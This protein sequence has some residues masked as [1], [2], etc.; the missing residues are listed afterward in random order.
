MIKVINN[1][2]DNLKEIFTI[3]QNLFPS[4]INNIISPIIII[5]IAVLIYKLVRKALI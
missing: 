2:N 1:F 4:E 5:L 3:G